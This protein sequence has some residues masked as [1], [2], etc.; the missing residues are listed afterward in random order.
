MLG[1]ARLRWR[2]DRNCDLC[3]RSYT[4]FDRAWRCVCGGTLSIHGFGNADRVE[5]GEGGTPLIRLPG[6][7]GDVW[8]KLEF[9]APTGSFKDR[10]AAAMIARLKEIGVQ[11]VADD[12]AGNAG[13]SIAAYCAA[14]GI[15]CRIYVARSASLARIGVIRFYGAEVTIVDGD[16]QAAT[17]AALDCGAYY[18]GHAWD[19][20][21]IHGLCPL[22][23]EIAAVPVS[24]IFLPLGQGT[25]LLG[26]LKGF[27]ELV[28]AGRLAAAPLLIAVQTDACAPIAEMARAGLDQLRR[29]SGPRASSP[30]ASRWLPR[31]AGGV[32]SA[33]SGAVPPGSSL[34]AMRRSRTPCGRLGAPGCSSS[35]P[36][37]SCWT[38]CCGWTRWKR[39]RRVG[40]CFC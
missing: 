10:G 13:V 23:H 39:R 40:H 31:S 37:R 1:S 24:R 35:R 21:F 5:L 4:Y 3:G 33:S 16:R 30:M 28:A 15:A 6:F 22:A 29:L 32:C 7:A 38:R 34:Q 18:A 36:P 14:A 12:S 17:T 26:L 9:L 19:P 8:T 11:A 20:F 2:P 27:E 25:L